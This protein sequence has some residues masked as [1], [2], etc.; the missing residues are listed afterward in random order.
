[1]CPHLVKLIRMEK[2]EF[3]IELRKNDFLLEYSYF[4]ALISGRTVTCFGE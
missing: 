4:C 1:M 3:E 2:E